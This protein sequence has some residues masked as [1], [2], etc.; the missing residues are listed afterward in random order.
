MAPTTPSIGPATTVADATASTTG[1]LV[2][3]SA[4]V[5]SFADD[6]LCEWLSSDKI[7]ELVK[8]EYEWDGTA[9]AGAFT[10]LIDGCA[11]E[12][13]G[14]PAV[15]GLNTVSIGSARAGPPDEPFVDY[16]DLG[17]AAPDIGVGIRG[18][19]TLSDGVIYTVGGFGYVAF[20]VPEHGFINVYLWVPG[21]EG[22]HDAHFAFADAL[23]EELGWT[24]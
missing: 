11:W 19:P 13:S 7:A 17:G 15:E 14:T 22:S 21:D 16:D 8:A 3:S 1:E 5:F 2:Q 23:I 20:G 18:H 9:T 6:D 12:L 10:D 24:P 4:G